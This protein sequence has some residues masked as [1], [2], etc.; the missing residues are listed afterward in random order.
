MNDKVIR[1]TRHIS[2]LQT[3][4]KN[5]AQMIEH[6]KKQLAE[7]QKKTNPKPQAKKAPAKKTAPKK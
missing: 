7:A 4:N 3:K 5:Q 2:D 6:L 1:R